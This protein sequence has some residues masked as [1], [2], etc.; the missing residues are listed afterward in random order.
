MDWNRTKGLKVNHMGK[1][2][3]LMIKTTPLGSL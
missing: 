2:N 1:L 3:G